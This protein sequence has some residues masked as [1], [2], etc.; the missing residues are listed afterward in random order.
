MY[1]S[2]VHIAC[3]DNLFLDSADQQ[4]SRKQVHPQ[5]YR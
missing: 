4:I 3:V 2:E 1:T 5:P